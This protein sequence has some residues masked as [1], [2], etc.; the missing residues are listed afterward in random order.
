MRTVK[1]KKDDYCFLGYW[2]D[3][4]KMDLKEIGWGVQSGFTWLRIG[5][6]GRLL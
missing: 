6:V 5:M 2:E 3:G 1:I 4:I